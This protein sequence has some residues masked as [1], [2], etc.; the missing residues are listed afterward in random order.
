MADLHLSWTPAWISKGHCF[1]YSS[2]LCLM[3]L[4]SQPCQTGWTSSWDM[5]LSWWNP[6]R[7]LLIAEVNFKHKVSFLQSSVWRLI[8][9]PVLREEQLI[10]GLRPTDGGPMQGL[11]EWNTYWRAGPSKEK[12]LFTHCSTTGPSLQRAIYVYMYICHL[13]SQNWEG[14]FPPECPWSNRAVATLDVDH[15]LKRVMDTGA[16]LL[17]ATLRNAVSTFWEPWWTLP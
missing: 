12:E 1:F 16:C 8:C 4:S 6:H 17:L 7:G 9:S 2:L 10:A 15:R 14:E 11:G 3:I 13:I 5:K